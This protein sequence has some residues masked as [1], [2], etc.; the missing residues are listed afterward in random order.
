M[1][2]SPDGTAVATGDDV[3]WK[4]ENQLE[5]SC[6]RIW[7]AR[8]GRETK[9]FG[10]ELLRVEALAFS[11]DGQFLA[12]GSSNYLP[13]APDNADFPLILLVPRRF[14]TLQSLPIR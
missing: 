4:N 9:R 6:I 1:A 11:S 5:G 8:S 13:Q 14:P 12:S 7:D 10:G 3:I 2:V